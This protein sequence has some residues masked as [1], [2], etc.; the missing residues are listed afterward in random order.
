MVAAN[1]NIHCFILFFCHHQHPNR[2]IFRA[3]IDNA[4]LMFRQIVQAIA[5][6]SVNRILDHII[7]I[8]KKEVS[9]LR[10]YAA[11]SLCF[12]RN[13][14]KDHDTHKF[15]HSNVDQFLEVPESSAPFLSSGRSGQNFVP[16]APYHNWNYGVARR[17]GHP[18]SSTLIMLL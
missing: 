9:K 7:P 13:V 6:A 8:F 2:A 15:T 16:S 18:H 17:I 14:K 4:Q 12:D 3:V 5:D 10:R 1:Q 11:L